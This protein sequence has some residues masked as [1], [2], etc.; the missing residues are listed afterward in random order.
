ML[1]QVDIDRNVL[2]EPIKVLLDELTLKHNKLQYCLTVSAKQDS[3]NP[4]FWTLLFNDPRFTK[5]EVG[6]VGSVSWEWGSRTDKE[7]K[8]KSRLI[9]NDRFGHW[10]RDERK[11]KRTKD[12]KKAVKAILEFV[13][14]Y[15]WQELMMEERSNAQRASSKWKDESDG[16]QYRFKPEVK[17]MV[18]ELKNLMEQKV[19]FKTEAFKNMLQKIPEWEEMQRRKS[20]PS[21]FDSVMFRDDKVIYWTHDGALSELASVDALPEKHRNA[22]ALLKLM[23]DEQHLPEVGYKGKHQKYFVYI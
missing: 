23:N 12:V 4:E 15:M 8:I 21:K 3:H 7:Y 2:S 20:I 1:Q 16:I 5:E 18:E 13:K 10:N 17:E 14:P 6:A 9:D 22:I 11:A 19:I